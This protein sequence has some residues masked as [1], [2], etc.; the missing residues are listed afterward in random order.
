MRRKGARVLLLGPLEV[1][2]DGRAV[3]LTGRQRALL[4]GLLLDAGRVVSVERLAG[5]LWGEDLPPSAA[6]RVRALI[7]ELRRALGAAEVIVTRSP[8][9]L[10]PAG[11]V[12]VDADEFAALVATARREAGD[13]L[14][15]EAITTYDRALELWRG[16]PYPDLGGPV[17]EAERHRLDELRTEAIEG[18]A[19]A[20][21]AVGR[22]QAVIAGLAR[23][24]AE[25]PLRERPHGLLMLALHRGGRLPEALRVYREFRDRLVRE[26]GVEPGRDLQ[27]LHQSI[28]EEDP[29]ARPAPVPRQLPPDTGRFVGREAELPRMDAGRVT[30]LVGPAG[31][32]KTALA[33]HWAHRRAGLFP[34]GQ[35]FLDLRGFDRR[36]PMP[37]SEALPLLLQGLGQAAKDIPVELD[38]QIALYRSLLAGRRVLLVLD[39]VAEPD[40][41]RPLL[42]GDPGCRVVIT[43]RHRLGGLVALDGV[44]R[45]TLGVLEPGEALRLISAGV[46]EERL[47]REPEAA[48]ELVA[49][50]D[51]SP[52]A[53]SIAVSW[54]GDHEH[55]RI[56]DYVRELAERGRLVRLRVDGDE[57]VA[58]R[59]ALDLSYRALPA[60]AQ[61]VFRL[62]GLARGAGI[63]AAAVAALAGTDRERAEVLLG[64]A[65]R[66]HLI[67][68]IGPR[69][70]AAHDL[71]GEY[72]A[73]RAL[74]EDSEAEREAAVRRLFDH[75]LSTTVD[76][77]T[78]AGFEV[79]ET[80]GRDATAFAT[81]AQALGWL[82]TEWDN[83]TGV[84]ASGARPY[85]WLL[86]EAMTDVLQHRRT[87]AEWLRLAETALAAAERDGDLRG[88]AAMCYSIGRARLLTADLKGA[89][90]F[91]ERAQALCRLAGWSQ[92]EA[93]V[94]QSRG[95][96]LKQLGEPRRAIPLYQRAVEIHRELGS[97]RGEA[98]GLNNL[99]SANLMLARLDRAEECLLACL[100]LTERSGDTHLRTLTLVN[101]A[102]VRQK[103]ARLADA[104]AYLEEALALAQTA[105]LRY[106]EAVTHETF[107]WV[108]RDAGRHERAIDA[109]TRALG[110]AEEVENRRCQIASLTGT[111]AVETELGRTDDALAHLDAAARLAERTGTDLDEVLLERA[112]AHFRQG[113]YEDARK[114]A[115]QALERALTANPLNLPRAHVLLAAVHLAAGDGEECVRACER[116][117]GLARRSGQRLQYARALTILGH[118]RSREGDDGQAARLWTRA[119]AL[120]TAIGAPD[121]SE[122]VALL[123]SRA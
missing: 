18:R 48:R 114:E 23:V 71:V 111:A 3:R 117:I 121:R 92:G 68:E 106:A 61:R 8:G 89:M 12:D 96:V 63:S 83:L 87:R 101:L 116:A 110:I 90:G 60:P 19:D 40:Q 59:A 84:I 122:T 88:Q 45:L 86:A 62:L 2:V 107:G 70:F 95:V 102:L 67:E 79:P 29:A 1:V 28:L 42:P 36:A 78:V 80:P 13:G 39:D 43:S 99:A 119:H 82:D 55:R 32:G 47:R 94:L 123:G 4:A 98:R 21:L 31:V 85:A 118:A 77:L 97:V 105:G 15:A 41:I 26:L 24:V 9:Y 27:S 93:S 51:H 17:A 22:H 75:Y 53:L 49:L 16:D 11:A 10:V 30:L 72:A 58:V 100:A 38:A 5:R 103:Q 25:Q 46:G 120:F 52:L 44:E 104:L 56:A 112:G 81:A 14:H 66:I 33:L 57:S 109:F 73:Q 37:P 35:L 6:A 20:Q 91:L 7:A 54:I 65:A 34:D 115:G 113:R 108:H 76:A 74:A 69:R 64:T 50:C